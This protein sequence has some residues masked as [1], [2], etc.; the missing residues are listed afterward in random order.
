MYRTDNRMNCQ[1]QGSNG[2]NVDP[3]VSL[4]MVRISRAADGAHWADCLLRCMVSWCWHSMDWEVEDQR[5]NHPWLL[6][7]SQASLRCI[8]PCPKEGQRD[9]LQAPS[10]QSGNISVLCQA[11][12]CTA[13]I[14]RVGKQREGNLVY[15]E[16]QD[17]QGYIERP[18]LNI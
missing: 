5:F 15:K 10:T 16:F 4:S 8:G 6:S 9:K 17:N 1:R 2:G 12:Q 3:S 18:C 14:L 7:E 11:W 13:L